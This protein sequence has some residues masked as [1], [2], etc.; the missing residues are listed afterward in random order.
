MDGAAKMFLE[1][2]DSGTSPM[3]FVNGM[4]KKGKLILGIGHRIKSVRMII[5]FFKYLIGSLTAII[6]DNRI[7]TFLISF[8]AHFY[9]V[10]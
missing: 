10:C 3:D 4:R 6:S 9:R 8:V 7:K 2:H 5:M 1:A